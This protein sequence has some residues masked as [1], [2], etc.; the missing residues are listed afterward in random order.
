LGDELEDMSFDETR[1]KQVGETEDH[2]GN[3]K[4]IYRCKDCGFESRIIGISSH[5]RNKHESEKIKE[6]GEE[7]IELVD[8]GKHHGK[9][10]FDKEALRSIRDNLKSGD[11]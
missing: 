8:H 5:R 6:I 10:N 7:I 11:S 9:G 2:L 3:K 1:V 4:K